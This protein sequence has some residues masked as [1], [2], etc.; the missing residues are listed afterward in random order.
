MK[1]QGFGVHKPKRVVSLAIMCVSLLTQVSC[2]QKSAGTSARLNPEN[3]ILIGKDGNTFDFGTKKEG[4][5]VIARVTIMNRGA[6]SVKP[7]VVKSCGCHNATLSAAEIGPGQTVILVAE[8]ST[9]GRD[10]GIHEHV[11]LIEENRILGIIWIVG[12]V[13]SMI[14]CIASPP[15]FEFSDLVVGT[16]RTVSLSLGAVLPDDI[17]SVGLLDYEWTD[18]AHLME[19]TCNI[20]GGRMEERE[21][22]GKQRR[23]MMYS[24][25]ICV[26]PQTPGLINRSAL[27]FYFKDEA[28]ANIGTYG[29]PFIGRVRAEVECNPSSIYVGSVTHGSREECEL[30]V[31]CAE[32]TTSP[33]VTSGCDWVVPGQIQSIDGGYLIKVV[34]NYENAPLGIFEEYLHIEGPTKIR[35]PVVGFCKSNAGGGNIPIK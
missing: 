30:R 24:I 19:V 17:E 5:S 25:V 4:E 12:Q 13:R 9:L 15:Y 16:T 7:K 1:R 20:D 18:N 26:T 10:G 8:L 11:Q 22:R 6:A 28:G 29:L 35:V 3:F 31:N 23:L 21:V 2:D 33:T 27:R 14:K 32:R 34:L